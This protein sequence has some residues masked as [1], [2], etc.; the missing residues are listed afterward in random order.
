MTLTRTPA[1]P[2]GP[3]LRSAALEWLRAA[4]ATYPGARAHAAIRAALGLV[5]HDMIRPETPP[6]EE[7][8]ADGSSRAG[9][10]RR[11]AA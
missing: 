2:Y 1:R 4:R 10:A 5:I 6:A 9:S 11:A 3:S 8:G 7:H